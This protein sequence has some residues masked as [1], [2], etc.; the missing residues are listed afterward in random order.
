[1]DM[2][3]PDGQLCDKIFQKFRR[4]IFPVEEPRP[5]GMAHRLDGRTF[6]ASNFLIRLSSVRTMGM[7]VRTAIL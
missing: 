5:D 2:G 6:A 7:N 1:M 4:E 3:R